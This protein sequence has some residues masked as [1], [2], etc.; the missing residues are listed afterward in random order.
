MRSRKIKLVVSFY[1]TAD[2]FAFEA[3]CKQAG[4]SGRLGTVPRQMSAGCGMAW[5]AEPESCD[6]IVAMCTEQH[7]EYEDM[8]EI[9]R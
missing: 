5:Y 7:L 3:A 9:E 8:A 2:A 1:T 6:R 4:V